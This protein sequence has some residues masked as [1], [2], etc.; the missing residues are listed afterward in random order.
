[1]VELACHNVALGVRLERRR[2]ALQ[3]QGQPPSLSTRVC[4]SIV[5][6]K[7]PLAADVVIAVNAIVPRRMSPGPAWQ[8][9]FTM[10]R[11]RASVIAPVDVLRDL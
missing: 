11:R 4:G 6:E 7:D 8:L 2:E 5:K 10:G 9:P 3:V 1:M